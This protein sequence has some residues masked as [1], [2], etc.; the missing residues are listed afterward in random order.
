MLSL[1]TSKLKNQTDLKGHWQDHIHPDN[2][3]KFWCKTRHICRPTKLHTGCCGHY[4]GYAIVRVCVCVF[5]ISKV[6]KQST[7]W[8]A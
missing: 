8:A 4:L 1:I 7:P 6:F 2:R 5:W 3:G